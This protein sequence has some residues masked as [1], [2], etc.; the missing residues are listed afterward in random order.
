MKSF[1]VF[2]LSVLLASAAMAQQQTFT[3]KPDASEVKITLNTNHETVHGI[4]H[5]QS[6]AIEFDRGAHKMSGSV[7]VFAGSGKTGNGTRDKRMNKEILQVERYTTV[8]FAPKS[9]SGTLAPLGDST[10]QVTGVF[11][12]LGTPHTIT[13]PI[14]VHVEGTT[15]TAKTLYQVP[16]IEW[17]LKNPSLLFWKADKVVAMDLILTGLISK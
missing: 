12:L 9:Y 15:A 8:S 11:T 14:H 7:I 2:A 6:G 4:F 3:I 16:Y 10:I 17:G 13:I 1:S 5:L